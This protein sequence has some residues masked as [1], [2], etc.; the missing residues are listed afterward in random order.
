MAVEARGLRKSYGPRVAVDGISLHVRR[1]E[2]FGFLGPNGAGKTT[3]MRMLACLSSRDSGDLRVLGT[4]PDVHPRALKARLGVVPQE[5]NLDLELTVLGNMLVYARYFGI[6]RRDARARAMELLRFVDLHE[7]AD[8]AVARLS[9]G[10]Q[11]RLQIARA[12]VNDPEMI[13]LDEPTTGLDPQARRLVWERLRELRVRGT[14]V[15]ITTHYMDEAE[16]L[17]DRLVVIDHGRVVRE[18]APAT[19]VRAEVGT[20]VLEMRVRDPRAGGAARLA[21]AV[22]GRHVVAGD[23]VLAFGDDPVALRRRARAAPVP[24]DLV[25]ERPASL[26]DLFIVLT[27]H[28]LREEG[29]GGG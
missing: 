4:D 19:L 16:R 6:G 1:G 18:G 25:A 12:L 22:A 27:G 29:A 11:R 15:V 13:L 23:V 8:D 7:R 20:A 10:M 3:T 5:V 2:C 24:W 21:A 14:S 9:G 26:E 28:S 17:C